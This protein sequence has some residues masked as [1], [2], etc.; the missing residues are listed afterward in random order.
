VSIDG[1]PQT[2]VATDPDANEVRVNTQLGTIEFGT[3]LPVT[4]QLDV[5]WFIGEWEVTVHRFQGTL[6]VEIYGATA[7]EID[8][9]SS[10]V[11]QAIVPEAQAGID[12]LISVSPQFFGP[13]GPRIIEAG[14]ARRR[15]V[16]FVIDAEIEDPLLL[17]GGGLISQIDIDSTFGAEA[18]SVPGRVDA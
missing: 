3:P 10:A 17:G 4:G 9:L 2:I 8:D 1:A 6:A 14:N 7:A 18:F 16:E 12:G 11:E 13:T 15:R 5:A